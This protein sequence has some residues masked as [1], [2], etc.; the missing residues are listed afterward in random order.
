MM[1]YYNGSPIEERLER[2][3][4]RIEI[5]TRWKMTIR[6]SVEECKFRSVG[7]SASMRSPTFPRC[8]LSTNSVGPYIT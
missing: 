7:L 3:S 4:E 5:W 8:L 1:R 2:E 6:S